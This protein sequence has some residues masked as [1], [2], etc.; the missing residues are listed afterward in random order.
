M[1]GVDILLV[2]GRVLDRDQMNFGRTQRGTAGA[3]IHK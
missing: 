3:T 2:L 1:Y